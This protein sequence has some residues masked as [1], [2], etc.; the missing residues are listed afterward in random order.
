MF[1]VLA[2]HFYGLQVLR[3]AIDA[4]SLNR[5]ASILR[6]TQPAV[7]R[8]ISRLEEALGCG[9]L[10]RSASGVR[11]TVFAETILAHL[12][13]AG[14]ELDMAG[15]SLTALRRNAAGAVA[16]AGASVNIPIVAAAASHFHQ[17]HPTHPVHLFEGA[18]PAMLD[19]LQSGDVDIVVGSRH[20]DEVA[21][22]G[23]VSVPLLD[24]RLGVFSR[25]SEKPDEEPVALS[26]L[27]DQGRWVFPGPGTHLYDYIH[28]ELA[29]LEMAP[30]ARMIEAR[31]S[32]A[33]RWLVH[34]EGYRAISTSLVHGREIRTGEI[35]Q[36]QTDWSFP[37]AKHV[38]YRKPRHACS[39]SA[40][41]LAE[42]IL[43]EAKRHSDL[44]SP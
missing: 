12:R 23:I 20:P 9:L 19:L 13:R 17:R 4:G 22:K 29:R 10:E 5:A 39:R 44:I 25:V 31:S 30:P 11:P 24:E 8:S 2:R 7:T 40:L 36:I 32:S 16:C 1:E 18:T 41:E 26:R 34:H 3:I 27:F 37:V 35:V 21:L 43:S 42:I 33:I 28:S 14:T 38:L 15:Q 6:V